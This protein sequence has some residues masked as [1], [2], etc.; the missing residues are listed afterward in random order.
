MQV[1]AAL[2]SYTQLEEEALRGAGGGDEG[3]DN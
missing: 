2:I 3:V 1:I